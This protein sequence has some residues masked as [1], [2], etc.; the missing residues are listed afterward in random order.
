M[1]VGF[2][3][4]PLL[5]LGWGQALFTLVIALIFG[6]LAPANWELAEA[7][8]FD[9]TVGATVGVLIGVFA[10]PCGG[11]GELYQ[12]TASFL[13]ARAAVVRET[14]ATA[15]GGAGPGPALP[16][17]RRQGQLAEASYALYQTERHE[18]SAVDWQA[19]LNAG[20]DAVS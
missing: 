14:V 13:N 18:P 20:H 7:R 16:R 8:L 3:A 1:L 9:V 15:A 2:A 11:A 5:G 12:A 19:T 4:G 17:A 10:W 6:Q